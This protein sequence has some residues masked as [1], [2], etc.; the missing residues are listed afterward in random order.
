MMMSVKSDGATQKRHAK[1]H[2]TE[3]QAGSSMSSNSV[4]R[5]SQGCPFLL[6]LIGADESLVEK[7]GDATC[8]GDRFAEFVA[9]PCRLMM[10]RTRVVLVT[11]FAVC[12]FL[13]VF[14]IRGRR[15]IFLWA[16]SNCSPQ[17]RPPSP[18]KPK[19]QEDPNVETPSPQVQCVTLLASF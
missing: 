11:V 14:F 3:A 7:R 17:A 4:M 9:L 8:G 18:N 10:S 2:T 5:V 16:R 15:V 13:S 12:H 1:E 19:A 6:F